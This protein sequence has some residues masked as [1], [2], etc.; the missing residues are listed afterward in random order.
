MPINQPTW[1]LYVNRHVALRALLSHEK[2]TSFVLCS[3]QTTPKVKPSPMR[4]GK[5]SH[6]WAAH[7]GRS[8]ITASLT[9]S[10]LPSHKRILNPTA[11]TP[12]SLQHMP[13]QNRTRGRPVV[14]LT[15]A[16]STQPT[17]ATRLT[18]HCTSAAVFESDPCQHVLCDEQHVHSLAPPSHTPQ[19]HT[20]TH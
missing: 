16:A 5:S 2:S 3:V 20:H 14:M 7:A 9:L 8:T 12:A 19:A 17:A 1:L 15:K 4:C 11:S 13:L 10:H 6:C 18:H